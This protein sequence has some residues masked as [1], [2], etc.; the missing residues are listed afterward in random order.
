MFSIKD[1]LYEL[2]VAGAVSLAIRVIRKKTFKK[3]S[4]KSYWN[5]L[6]KVIHQ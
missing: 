3:V 5:R 6:I 1:A 4:R 2:Y